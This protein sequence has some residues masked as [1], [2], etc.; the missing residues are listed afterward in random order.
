MQNATSDD[1][2]KM[3]FDRWV[4]EYGIRLH[5]TVLEAAFDEGFVVTHLGGGALALRKDSDEDDSY[6]II[7]DSTDLGDS[8][9]VSADDWIVGR[10]LGHDDSTQSAVIVEEKTTL[11]EALRHHLSLPIPTPQEDGSASYVTHDT[12]SRSAPGTN[13]M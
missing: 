11:G 13:H 2:A 1:G 4:S 6:W 7:S 12:W 9:D 5:G 8:L 10:Y 3:S